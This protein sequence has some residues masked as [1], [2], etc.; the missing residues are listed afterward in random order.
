V[1]LPIL[2]VLCQELFLQENDE[3]SPFVPLQILK[4][5]EM[6]QESSGK[7]KTSSFLF[8]LHEKAGIS[9]RTVA[10]VISMIR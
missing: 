2:K 1:T 6:Q 10:P 9:Y 5:K 7:S 3:R 8:S 4:K